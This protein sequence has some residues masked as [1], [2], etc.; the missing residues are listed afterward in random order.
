ML[1]MLQWLYTYIASFYFQCFIHFFRRILQVCSFRCC[2]CLNVFC[3]CF[4]L[5]VAYVSTKTFQ[6][7]AASVAFRC[8]KSRSGVT[9]IAMAPVA[10]GQRPTAGFWLLPCAAS[11][12]L[13]SPLPPLS[14]LPSISPRCW[15]WSGGYRGCCVRTQA[16]PWD[17]MRNVGGVGWDAGR[18]RHGVRCRHRFGSSVRTSPAAGRTGASPSGN[19]KLVM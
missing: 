2:I 14:S 7:Y 11:L 8:S 18:G 15:R 19:K 16:L 17:E 12:A 5:D 10:G 1:H 3:K 6:M 13:S 4:C 9:H